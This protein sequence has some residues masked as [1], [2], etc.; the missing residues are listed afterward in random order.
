VEL[1]QA[2]QHIGS[3]KSYGKVIVQTSS[4]RG[5]TAKL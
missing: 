4:Q 2:L 1:P 3:R 5:S